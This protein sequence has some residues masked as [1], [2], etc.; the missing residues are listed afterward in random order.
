MTPIQNI[1]QLAIVIAILYPVYYVA[2]Y[3]DPPKKLSYVEEHNCKLTERKEG[4][5]HYGW[6]A[7]SWGLIYESSED[8]YLCD[9]GVI[10]KK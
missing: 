8:T 2:R 6:V 3:Y 5:S 4:S 7:G 1:V 10:Y 9:N